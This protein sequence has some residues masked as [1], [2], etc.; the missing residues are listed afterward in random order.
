MSTSRFTVTFVIIPSYV[1]IITSSEKESSPSSRRA[2]QRSL[3]G[4][5]PFEVVK[6]E[7]EEEEE[8][9]VDPDLPFQVCEDSKADTFNQFPSKADEALK[10]CKV[11]GVIMVTICTYTKLHRSK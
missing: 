9:F 11:T 2:M 8:G 5:N 6:A 1:S 7:E 3:S 4:S 10:T